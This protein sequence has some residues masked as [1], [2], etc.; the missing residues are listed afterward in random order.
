MNKT[1]KRLIIIAVIVFVLGFVTLIPSA[2]TTLPYLQQVIAKTESQKQQTL[3]ETISESISEIVI[4]ARD[5]AVRIETSATNDF[6]VQS[7]NSSMKKL[8]ITT[9][10]NAEQQLRIQAKSILTLPKI[11][12]DANRFVEEIIGALTNNQMETVVIQVPKDQVIN[13]EILNAGDVTIVDSERLGAE[14]QINHSGKFVI[15]NP[16][17][18]TNSKKLVYQNFVEDYYGNVIID[19]RTLNA[20]TDVEISGG[21][22][23]SLSNASGVEALLTKTLVVEASYINYEYIPFSGTVTLRNHI[24]A[25]MDFMMIPNINWQIQADNFD[26]FNRYGEMIVNGSSWQFDGY[27]WPDAEKATGTMILETDSVEWFTQ[28]DTQ[29]ILDWAQNK[30]DLRIEIMGETYSD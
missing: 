11:S 28:Q 8:E 3:V 16:V 14:T 5:I 9:E 26:V 6:Q 12:R 10:T 23:V 1:N 21:D 7:E 25:Y 30:P 27:F 2:F 18:P 22:Y 15:T 20:F 29:E 13:L 17:A 24:R 4:D 19:Y